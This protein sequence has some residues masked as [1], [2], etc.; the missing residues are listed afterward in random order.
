[1]S[2]EGLP[3]GGCGV[4]GLTEKGHERRS[5][6]AGSVLSLDLSAGDWVMHTENPPSC[7]P[8]INALDTQAVSGVSHLGFASSMPLSKF[9]ILFNLKLL[10]P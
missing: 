5:Q 4:G 1:M 10:K 3:R 6:D 2:E 8:E 9:L 7:T